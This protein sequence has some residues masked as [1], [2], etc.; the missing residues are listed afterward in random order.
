VILTYDLERASSEESEGD[1]E[2]STNT[3]ETKAAPLE[4][5]LANVSGKKKILVSSLS[6]GMVFS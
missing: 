5:P 6:Q 3:N 2:Q 4:N 1:D